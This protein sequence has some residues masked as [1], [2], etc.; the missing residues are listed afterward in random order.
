VSILALLLKKEKKARVST[1]LGRLPFP[2]TDRTA[3]GAPRERL[4]RQ[5]GGLTQQNQRG[6]PHRRPSPGEGKPH[7]TH[8]P[9]QRWAAAGLAQNRR[10]QHSLAASPAVRRPAP[11]AA[12]IGRASLPRSAAGTGQ[13]RTAP[14]P[15][16]TVRRPSRGVEKGGAHY[17]QR[18]PPALVV[19]RP[20]PPPS[21]T[22]ST[23]GCYISKPFV[24]PIKTRES[25]ARPVLGFRNFWVPGQ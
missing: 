10:A 4:K 18:E 24:Q 19:E 13:A 16:V 1:R 7:R 15:T 9:E 8:W 6:G 21:K 25:S 11:C 20:S 2:A 22:P 12:I 5:P 17:Q 3:L 14:K 23:Q